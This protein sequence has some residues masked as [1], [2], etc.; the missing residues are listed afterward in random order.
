ML[1]GFIINV[2]KILYP[3]FYWILVLHRNKKDIILIL[4]LILIIKTYKKAL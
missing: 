1:Y 4:I 2:L 3:L